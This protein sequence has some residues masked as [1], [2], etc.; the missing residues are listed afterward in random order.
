MLEDFRCWCFVR[1]LVGGDLRV[2][3]SF[4]GCLYICMYGI[5]RIG[6]GS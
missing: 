1:Y 3:V 4:E 6:L 5:V 2:S